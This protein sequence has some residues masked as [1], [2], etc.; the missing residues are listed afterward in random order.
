VA[1]AFTAGGRRFGLW[2]LFAMTIPTAVFG[3]ALAVAIKLG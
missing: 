2:F 3:V 1:L